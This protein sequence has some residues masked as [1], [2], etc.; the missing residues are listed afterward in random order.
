M[1]GGATEQLLAVSEG[2]LIGLIDGAVGKFIGK[3]SSFGGGGDGHLDGKLEDLYRAVDGGVRPAGRGDT[4]VA[5]VGIQ[6][7][8][9]DDL[10]GIEYKR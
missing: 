7:I 2:R 8:R 10:Q 6:G 1:A 3:R 9:A 4:G 5:G